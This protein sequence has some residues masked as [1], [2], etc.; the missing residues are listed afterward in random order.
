M[1]RPDHSLKAF[2]LAGSMR[3]D[4]TTSEA[5]VWQ[6]LKGRGTGVRFRRQVPIGS[7]IVD[8][9]CLDPKLVIEVDDPSHD[10][11]DEQDRMAFLRSQG[12]AVVSVTNREVATGAV[13]VHDLVV[14]ALE[15]LR[16][17]TDPCELEGW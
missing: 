13:D 15:A 1:A 5:A 11:K 14:A 3:R 10:W 7:Y 4:M 12:F 9:A 17:G 16:A 2:R 8:F 6:A